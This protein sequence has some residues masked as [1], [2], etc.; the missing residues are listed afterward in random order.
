MILHLEYA[1]PDWMV[2]SGPWLLALSTLAWR[3]PTLHC[4]MLRTPGGAAPA[5]GGDA[6]AQ[7]AAPALAA[8]GAGR[9]RARQD[10]DHH[11]CAAGGQGLAHHGE[12]EPGARCMSCMRALLVDKDLHTTVSGSQAP[13]GPGW[14]MLVGPGGGRVP[15]GRGQRGAQV[16][17]AARPPVA[18]LG[19]S[20]QG[21]GW[22]DA[23]AP[24]LISQGGPPALRCP[25]RWC[26]RTRRPHACQS[27]CGCASSPR[28]T[29]WMLTAG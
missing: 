4:A 26:G 9:G 3:R 11:P 6:R 13:A 8:A 17:R 28:R 27:R 14:T 7:A 21:I 15:D 16:C 22:V 10:V 2:S 25:G 23:S 19:R 24:R 20:L 29:Q 18:R 5:Q 1:F 12:W